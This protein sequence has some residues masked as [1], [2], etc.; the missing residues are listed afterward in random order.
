MKKTLIILGCCVA[1]LLLLLGAALLLANGGEEAPEETAESLS[2]MD[3]PG[4]EVASVSVKNASGEYT[5]TRDGDALTVHDIPA[6]L[7]NMDY[8]DML[9]DEASSVQYTSLVTT[10]LSRLADY[11]LAEP[12]AE[13]EIS[14]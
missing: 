9:L 2:L 6:K 13:V 3:R 1:L 8:V 12:E 7:V 4:S 10:E 14:P 5:V 11:G